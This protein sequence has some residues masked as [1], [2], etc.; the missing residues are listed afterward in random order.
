[1]A[2]LSVKRWVLL[3]GWCQEDLQMVALSIYLS[4][5]KIWIIASPLLPQMPKDVLNSSIWEGGT[6]HYTS[7][8]IILI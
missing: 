4:L 1:M 6:E 3:P 8:K 5:S 7:V 2:A